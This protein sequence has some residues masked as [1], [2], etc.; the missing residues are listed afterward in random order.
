MEMLPPS[1][2]GDVATRQ[3]VD[4]LERDMDLR[5][6]LV[7]QRFDMLEAKVEARID[8]G[9]AALEARMVRWFVGTGVA[10]LGALSGLG[11]LVLALR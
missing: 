9:F 2:W 4:A 7:D 3:R 10:R 11:G 8:A 5:F 1:G 6:Q